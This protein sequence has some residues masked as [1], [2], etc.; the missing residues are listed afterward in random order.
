MRDGRLPTKKSERNVCT[1]KIHKLPTGALTAE[2]KARKIRKEK[3][4]QTSHAYPANTHW[5]R[6]KRRRQSTYKVS[7]WTGKMTRKGYAAYLKS[8]RWK[9]FSESYRLAPDQLQGCFVCGEAKYQLHHHNYARLGNEKFEDVVPLCEA[10][11]KAVH[12][13][14]KSGV[15]LDHAHSYV[16]MLFQS[17][18]LGVRVTKAERADGGTA[19]A[20]A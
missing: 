1:R 13:V 3:K 18:R 12:R 15:G 17:G 6:E 2:K 5:I 20:Q 8:L 19:D 7:P 16:K 4:K 10:H 11:H 14:V 9:E